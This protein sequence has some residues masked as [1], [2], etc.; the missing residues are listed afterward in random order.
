MR[1]FHDEDRARTSTD[2]AEFEVARGQVRAGVKTCAAA[3]TAYIK[4]LNAGDSQAFWPFCT[5]SPSSS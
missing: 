5:Y 2:Q 3:F 4:E 1:P